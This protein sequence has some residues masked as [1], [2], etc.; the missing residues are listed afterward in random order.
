MR[1]IEEIKE[2]KN[3]SKTHFGPEDDEDRISKKLQFDKE[4]IAYINNE[5]TKQI[6]VK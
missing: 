3:I 5:L 6:E 2:C 1:R 4:K